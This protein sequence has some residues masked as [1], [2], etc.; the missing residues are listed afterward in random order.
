MPVRLNIWLILLCWLLSVVSLFLV[1]ALPVQLN[2]FILSDQL[3]VVSNPQLTE[4]HIEWSAAII[5]FLFG[6]ITMAV[7][8]VWCAFALA[9]KQKSFPLAFRVLLISIVG[10]VGVEF[11]ESYLNYGTPTESDRGFLVFAISLMLVLAAF[12]H[13]VSGSH[14]VKERLIRDG[15]FKA[16][17][18]WPARLYASFALITLWSASYPYRFMF[19]YDHLLISYGLYVL[20]LVALA[21]T[22]AG[23]LQERGVHLLEAK[24]SEQITKEIGELS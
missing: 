13:Y 11:Y 14:A 18:T 24:K 3:L 10:T 2:V 20:I 15:L 16:R 5:L 22:I 4:Q 6:N 12:N 8:A 9:N 23:W 7:S 19:F 17:V 21:W 1:Y